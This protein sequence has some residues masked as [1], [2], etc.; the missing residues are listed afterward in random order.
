[1]DLLIHIIVVSIWYEI[2]T[3]MSA[4]MIVA[5]QYPASYSYYITC[6]QIIATSKYIGAMAEDSATAPL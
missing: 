3:L 4:V 2:Y 1:M 6:L 5:I